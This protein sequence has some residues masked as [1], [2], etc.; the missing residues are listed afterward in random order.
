M[1]LTTALMDALSGWSST[2]STRKQR[3]MHMRDHPSLI[4]V[5]A[6]KET[7]MQRKSCTTL[8][9]RNPSHRTGGTLLYP[10]YRMLKVRLIMRSAGSRHHPIN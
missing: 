5:R 1:R 2:T 6:Q 7:W 8:A 9:T 3:T 10:P 4:R